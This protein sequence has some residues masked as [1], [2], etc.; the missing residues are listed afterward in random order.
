MERD[1]SNPED[2][3]ED[4]VAATVREFGRLDVLVN[5]AGVVQRQDARDFDP[6]LFDDVMEFAFHIACLCMC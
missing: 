3:C 6:A 1:L 2:V 4:I 5:N